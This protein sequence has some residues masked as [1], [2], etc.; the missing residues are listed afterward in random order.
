MLQ[1]FVNKEMRCGKG[2]E[3]GEAGA[4]EWSPKWGVKKGSWMHCVFVEWLNGKRKV[5]CW[6]HYRDMRRGEER[7]YLMG[8]RKK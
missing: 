1:P 5:A 8:G 4:V 7:D 2:S 3:V 6:S